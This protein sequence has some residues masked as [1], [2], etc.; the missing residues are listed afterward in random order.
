M[1]ATT[2]NGRNVPIRC[3]RPSRRSTRGD[4]AA[5]ERRSAAV[6]RAPR[7]GHARRPPGQGRDRRLGHR[8]ARRGRA[9]RRRRRHRL[10][11]GRGRDQPDVDGSARRS[12]AA[13]AGDRGGDPGRLD[14]ARRRR[15]AGRARRAAR[16]GPGADGSLRRPRR[17]ACTPGTGR[18]PDRHARRRQPLHRGL[19]R[20]RRHGLADAALG[21]PR[22]VGKAL[23]EHHIEIAQRLHHNQALE[24][25]DLA[26]FLAGTPEFDAYRRDLFWAQ[27]YARF[28]RA[29]DAAPA[30]RTSSVAFWPRVTLR[31][32][33]SRA[34]TTTSPRRSTSA[35]SCW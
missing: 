2:I 30:G 1:P 13:A 20:H 17:V 16:H 15:L 10:R 4:H 34:T 21:Q 29:A 25:R 19:P 23:A 27:E 3:G 6:G 18:L 33:R 5:Q 22:N 8:D 14:G 31:A 24:D 28:N 7:G 9:R 26:V 11:H 32:S 35:R 12:A